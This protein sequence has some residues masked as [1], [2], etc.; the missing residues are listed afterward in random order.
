[1]SKGVKG[2]RKGRRVGGWRV[3]RQIEEEEGEVFGK[4]EEEEGE[5]FGK[6]EEEEGRGCADG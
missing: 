2:M 5:V 1:M 3:C 6:V 4:V